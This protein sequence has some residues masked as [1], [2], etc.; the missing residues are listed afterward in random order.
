MTPLKTC[1]VQLSFPES[2]PGSFN[3]VTNENA[4]IAVLQMSTGKFFTVEEGL[5]GVN[6][7]ITVKRNSDDLLSGEFSGILGYWGP[8]LDPSKDPPSETMSIENGFF[9]HTGLRF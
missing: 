5:T 3:C 6:G 1:N 9:K 7:T 4:I 2:G 8:G